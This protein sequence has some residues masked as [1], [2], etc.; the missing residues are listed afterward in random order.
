MNTV[1]LCDMHVQCVCFFLFETRA[2]AIFLREAEISPA[3]PLLY[4]ASSFKWIEL[5]IYKGSVNVK[6]INESNSNKNVDSSS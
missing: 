6:V 5:E 4:S 1:I 3:T 2:N